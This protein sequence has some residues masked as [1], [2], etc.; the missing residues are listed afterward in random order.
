MNNNG[1]R[2]HTDVETQVTHAMTQNSRRKRQWVVKDNE[3]HKPTEEAFPFHVNRTQHNNE[4][5]KKQKSEHYSA[6]IIVEIVNRHGETVPIRALLDTG[7]S[8]TIVLRDFVKQGRAKSYKGKH[9][10][11]STMGGQFSTNRKALLD[12]TFPEIRPPKY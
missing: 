3:K 4:P 8:S 2:T 11:W 10:T 12:F 5:K 7:T 1:Q 6:E 9:T